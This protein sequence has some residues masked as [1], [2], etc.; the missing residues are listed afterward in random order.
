MTLR[1]RLALGAFMG[2]LALSLLALARYRAD[3]IVAH[4]V[5]SALM[6]KLPEGLDRSEVHGRFREALASVGSREERLEWLLELSQFLEKRQVL[7]A[8]DL[9]RLL[10]GSGAPA[11][12]PPP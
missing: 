12:I 7:R 4:V 2:C 3:G 5:E 6:Q 11:A 10:G 8:E 1:R 9:E